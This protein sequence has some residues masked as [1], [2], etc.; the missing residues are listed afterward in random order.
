MTSPSKVVNTSSRD[1]KLRTRSLN[2]RAKYHSR[3]LKR[4]EPTEVFKT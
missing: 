3:N 4:D 1:M 2:K